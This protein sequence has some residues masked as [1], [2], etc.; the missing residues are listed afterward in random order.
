MSRFDATEACSYLCPPVVRICFHSTGI[1]EDV[2]QSGRYVIYDMRYV[3][4]LALE[5]NAWLK[6]R[7]ENAQRKRLSKLRW[8]L[9][10]AVGL[11]RMI[12]NKR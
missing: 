9:Q 7:K 12:F 10:G 6:G 4:M 8:I 5:M 1:S 2:D 11:H 3:D